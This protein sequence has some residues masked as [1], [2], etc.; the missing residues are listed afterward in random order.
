MCGTGAFERRPSGGER[1][2]C[3]GD[4]LRQVVIAALIIIVVMIMIMIVVIT[5]MQIISSGLTA[6]GLLQVG[7]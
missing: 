6:D 2:R 4:A 3:R 7:R 1:R 5:V